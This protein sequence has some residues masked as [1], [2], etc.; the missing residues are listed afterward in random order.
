[1][2]T[3]RGVLKKPGKSLQ[4]KNQEEIAEKCEAHAG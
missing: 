1:V 2:K 3:S 4:I